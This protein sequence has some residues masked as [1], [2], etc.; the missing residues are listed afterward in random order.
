MQTIGLIAAMPEESAALRR[1]IKGW[2]PVRLGPF[3]AAAC[4]LTGRRCLL[5][6]SGMGERRAAEAAQALIETGSSH[7]I[8]FGIAGALEAD[9]H[10]GD[11]LVLQAVCRLEQAQ[12]GP[13][14][15]LAA[16]PPAALHAAEQALSARSTRLLSGTALTTGGSQLTGSWTANIL[17]PVLEMETAGI[18]Q[19]AAQANIPFFALRAISDGPLAP[20]PFD[21]GEVT[22]SDA[23]LRP[24]KLLQAILRRPQ[25][26]TR[27]P[28]LLRNTH[29]AAQNAAIAL[30]AAVDY[31]E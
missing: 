11:V 3:S 25:I 17:H 26:L 2:Q 13:L 14:L 6:T 31:L 30:R 23:N 15:R 24:G 1:L 28:P 16:W 20:I 18:A 27:I 8:S 19:T 7:L 12:P 21:L 29:F 9:L 5:V 22:D 4:V 10:V